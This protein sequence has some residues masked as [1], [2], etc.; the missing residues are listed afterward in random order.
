MADIGDML[1]N[2][3]FEHSIETVLSE[4]KGSKD[5]DL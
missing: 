3:R 5:S 1:V 2:D 4:H